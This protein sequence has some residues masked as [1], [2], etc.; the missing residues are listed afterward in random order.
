MMCDNMEFSRK[1]GEISVPVQQKLVDLPSSVTSVTFLVRSECKDDCATR[2]EDLWIGRIEEM[3]EGSEE[4]N[5]V[6][7]T[8]DEGK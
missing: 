8:C 7:L 1:W 2:R 6:V 3:F 5:D 4:A